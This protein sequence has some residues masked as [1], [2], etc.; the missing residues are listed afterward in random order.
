MPHPMGSAMS[1]CHKIQSAMMSQWR[2][3]WSIT[4][5]VV[6]SSLYVT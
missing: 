2:G 4:L 1:A 6:M 5:A 3:S